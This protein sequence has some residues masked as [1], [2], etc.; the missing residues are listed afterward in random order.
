MI[1]RQAHYRQFDKLSAGTIT[2][3]VSAVTEEQFRRWRDFALRMAR[4]CYAEGDGVEEPSLT[5]V[6]G[7]LR[8]FFA[9]LK[10]QGIVSCIVDWDNCEPYPEG[11]PLAGFDS[12]TRLPRA[13]LCLPDMLKEMYDED[14][15]WG[16][17]TERELEVHLYC[18]RQW[19]FL[20]AES[21]L[22]QRVRERWLDP[23]ETCL[24]AGLDFATEPSMGVFGAFTAGDLRRM[25]PDGVP[26]WVKGE[27]PWPIVIPHPV[28]GVGFTAEEAGEVPFDQLPDDIPVWSRRYA[29]QETATGGGGES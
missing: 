1:V 15:V 23:I 21:I 24:R 13:P 28:P 27:V 10:R 3:E 2:P 22:F 4:T 26:D 16:W 17:A 14:Q 12:I 18:I 11:H 7:E 9:E 19:K 25:Y 29:L 6:I 5:W 20:E 8:G